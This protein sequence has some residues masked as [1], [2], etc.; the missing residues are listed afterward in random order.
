[1]G[2]VATEILLLTFFF[3]MWD[4]RGAI[5]VFVE[6]SDENRPLGRPHRRSEDNIKLGI[7]GVGRGSMDWIVLAQNWD[8]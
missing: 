6:R 8:R 5:R 3:V 2:L 4:R 1:V 7:Q